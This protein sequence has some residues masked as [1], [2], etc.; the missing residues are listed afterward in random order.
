MLR[1]KNGKFDPSFGNLILP[2]SEKQYRAP[3]READ[4]LVCFSKRFELGRSNAA[5]SQRKGLQKKAAP[6]S[7]FRKQTETGFWERGA[8]LGR[9]QA[10]L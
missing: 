9:A 5:A 3:T 10:S 2:G 7:V 1:E 4:F 8:L 6:L